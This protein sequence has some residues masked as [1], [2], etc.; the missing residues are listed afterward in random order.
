M[1]PFSKKAREMKKQSGEE[2]S[3]D[4]NAILGESET[5]DDNEWIDTELSIHPE[6]KVPSEQKYVFAFHNNESKPLKP[7]QLS[8][9]GIDMSKVGN[10]YVFTAFIRQTLSKDIQLK[11]TTIL[12]LGPNNEKL[13]RK[14]FDLSKVGTI[15][16]RSSR[17]WQFVFEQK[18][19]L[20]NDS[21]PK[22]GW[23]L[24][25]ELKKKHQLDLEQTWKESLADEAIQSLEKIVANATPLKPGEVNFMGIS[26]KYN[27]NED[28]A[29][30]VL[31]R[32]GSEK[33]LTLQ[34][35]PL[36]VEDSSG[37]VIA[38]GGF[39]L[40]EFEVKANTS[41]PW[42]FIFPQSLVTKKDADLSKWRVYP[43][44]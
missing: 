4:A 16:A 40:N 29:V 34:Q 9:S 11:E 27:E 28:L 6:W 44:Q 32:N 24:A 5:S 1:F 25:F 23:S 17:P 36:K 35:L 43:V 31:I 33:N 41:K 26:A 42:T 3:I 21:I 13:A 14:E 22:T 8:L 18:D 20:T 7:N 2:Q 12:L 10:K 30:T 38:Q 39:K 19:L 37:E 15:P